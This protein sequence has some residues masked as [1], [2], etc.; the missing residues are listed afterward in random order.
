MVIVKKPL[1]SVIVPIYNVAEYLDQCVTSILNQTY[2]KLEIILVDDG[3]TDRSGEI[4]DFYAQKDVRVKV[5]HKPNGGPDSARKMGIKAASGEYVGY[6][7]GDDWVDEC[8]YEE[9][10]QKAEKYDCDVVIGGIA[11]SYNGET[12]NRK[13]WLDEGYYD[14]Q[15]HKSLVVPN[16]LY[17]GIFYKT[18]VQT[19]LCDKIFKRNLLM[20]FQLRDGLNTTIADDTMVTMP[21][22]IFAKT[23]YIMNGYHYHYRI[24]DNSLKH[25]ACREDIKKQIRENYHF[26][27]GALMDGG[28]DDYLVHQLNIYLL[29]IMALKSPG[30]FDDAKEYL[31][32]YGGLSGKKKVVVYGAGQAGINLVNYIERLDN[33]KLVGWTDKNY[34]TLPYDLCAPECIGNMEYDHIL[35]AVLR[36][37]AYESVRGDLS[38]MEIPEAKIKWI[39]E[40]LILRADEIIA[41]IVGK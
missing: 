27:K 14:E 28:N 40:T 35:I 37:D 13:H 11:D 19:S 2:R 34:K 10:A 17:S 32:L 5:Y 31:K 24:R 39:D 3:S 23:I 25:Q 36:R 15:M 12:K 20:Q 30:L 6:V 1:I 9:M 18:I 26:W 16:V 7:D 29:Y 38:N 8:M 21:S 4:C 22:I 33:I 41:S